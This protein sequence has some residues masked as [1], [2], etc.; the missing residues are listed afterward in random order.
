MGSMGRMRPA[1]QMS[2][3]GSMDQMGSMG[4]IGPV[5]Q[6]GPVECSHCSGMSNDFEEYRDTEI[7]NPRKT[8]RH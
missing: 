7:K 1:G 5:G 3:M 4:R 6:M 2:R 8:A